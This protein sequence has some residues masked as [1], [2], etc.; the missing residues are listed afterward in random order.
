M[1]DNMTKQEALKAM[2]TGYKVSHRYFSDDEY[3]LMKNG[4]M[5]TEDGYYFE[6][7]FKRRTEKI[8]QTGW[9]IY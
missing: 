8:W 4:E 5:F 1:N 7:E 2:E 3:I 6:D 9:R